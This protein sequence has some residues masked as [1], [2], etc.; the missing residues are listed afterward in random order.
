MLGSPI[1]GNPYIN[2]LKWEVPLRIPS[3]EQGTLLIRAPK[4]HNQEM[5]VGFGRGSDH[6]LRDIPVPKP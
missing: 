2:V 4:P 6:S 5:V 1:F 3:Q